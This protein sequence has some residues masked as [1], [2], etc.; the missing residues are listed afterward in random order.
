M[1]IGLYDTNS[2]GGPNDLQLEA[3]ADTTSTGG[4]YYQWSVA[5]GGSAS[6]ITAGSQIWIG[7]VMEDAGDSVTYYSSDGEYAAGWAVLANAY[8]TEASLI[9]D[10]S[11]SDN[12]LPATVTPGGG[13]AYAN[14]LNMPALSFRPEP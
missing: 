4:I 12:A 9:Y 1:L 8:N 7:F 6:F 5:T 13:L 11:G 10:Y 14:G 3:T 2:V